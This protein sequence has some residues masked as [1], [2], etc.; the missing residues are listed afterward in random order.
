MYRDAQEADFDYCNTLARTVINS[1]VKI[2]S[3]LGAP[4]S[5]H[6][7]TNTIVR[8]CTIERSFL[9]SLIKTNEAQT[10]LLLISRVACKSCREVY[11]GKDYRGWGGT[12]T[13]TRPSNRGKSVSYRG[14]GRF[15]RPISFVYLSYVHAPM[16]CSLTAALINSNANHRMRHW[17]RFPAIR[18]GV[19]LKFIFR[20]SRIISMVCADDGHSIDF[21]CHQLIFP[22]SNCNFSSARSIVQEDRNL[23]SSFGVN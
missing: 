5:A 21:H 17:H 18:V 3:N 9:L 2:N 14:T 19:Y 23:F 20:E 15:H 16:Q 4:K 22:D 10:E 6:R 13:R 11:T 12:G 1:R 8:L 7:S